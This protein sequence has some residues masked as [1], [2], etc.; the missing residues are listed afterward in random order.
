MTSER[1]SVDGDAPIEQLRGESVHT[2]DDCIAALH[3]ELWSG[4]V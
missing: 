4:A 3:R 2:R 1:F